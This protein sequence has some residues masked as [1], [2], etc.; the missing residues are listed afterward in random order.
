ML[1]SP[2]LPCQKSGVIEQCARHGFCTCISSSEMSQ[3][4]YGMCNIVALWYMMSAFVYVMFISCDSLLFSHSVYFCALFM[5]V[6][7]SVHYTLLIY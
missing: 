3:F 2:S 5:L 1:F 4:L 6:T 7:A